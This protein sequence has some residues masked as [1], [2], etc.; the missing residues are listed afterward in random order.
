MR[1]GRRDRELLRWAALLHDVGKLK[2]PAPTLE[3]TGL[4]TD[5]DWHELR[6]HPVEGARLIAPLRAWLGPWSSTVVQHHE[7]WD[8]TG[9]PGGLA[10]IHISLGARIVAVADAFETMTAASSG[11]R[12]AVAAEAREE[13]TR[14]AGRQFDPVV[15]R[16]FLRI[17][18]GR[19]RWVMGPMAWLAEQPFLGG[20]QQAAVRVGTVGA[21]IG[22]GVATA[23]VVAGAVM[24]GTPTSS[25]PV[26]RPEHVARSQDARDGSGRG[27]IDVFLRQVGA[28]PGDPTSGRTT[29]TTAVP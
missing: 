12:P 22:V 21:R 3:R 6:R 24:A 25:P 19:L 14:C 9:Y 18:I 7:R 28:A 26:T 2:V 17:S 5:A 8:G 4:L 16:A 15:V 1:L 20:V 13:L 10:G 29:T 23:G 11:A 27:A